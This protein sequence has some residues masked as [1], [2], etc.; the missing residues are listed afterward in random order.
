MAQLR[1]VYFPSPT[2]SSANSLFN[3]IYLFPHASHS[4][5]SLSLSS[6]KSSF[7]SLRRH[8]H[9]LRPIFCSG[10]VLKAEN[11]T[12]QSDTEQLSLT[13]LVAQ[14]IPWTSTADEIRALFEKHGRV[15]DV[16]LS[17]HNKT[18]N[19]GLAFVEMGSP[20]EAAE[21][22]NKL[23]AREFEGRIL[24][25]NYAR[26]MKMKNPPP[27]QPKLPLAYNLFVANLSF[28]ARAKDLREFFSTGGSEVVSAEVIFHDNPR[29]SSGYGFVSFATKKE[30]EAALS[31]YQG[32]EFM[33][34]AIRVARSKRFV[35]EMNSQPEDTSEELIPNSV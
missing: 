1:P 20:G 31:S 15:I 35:K 10:S 25:L 30:A 27:V 13:R 32:K 6:S 8:S 29:R 18:R 14:N 4:L 23:E 17:M 7:L 22:L 9:H 2:S 19:R 26:P 24:K 12:L 34:R 28:E 3:S 33:G 5:P 11:P 21:A 16:E